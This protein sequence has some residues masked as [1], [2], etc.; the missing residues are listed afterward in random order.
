MNNNYSINIYNTFSS[1]TGQ[2]PLNLLIQ[3]FIGKIYLIKYLIC[4]ILLKTNN[5]YQ[6]VSLK[7]FLY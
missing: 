6:I 3:Y 5:Y 7:S 2:V 4:N 1:S